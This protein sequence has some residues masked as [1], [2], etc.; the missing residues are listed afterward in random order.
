MEDRKRGVLRRL[1][2]STELERALGGAYFRNVFTEYLNTEEEEALQAAY[3]RYQAS[4]FKRVQVNDEGDMCDV[5]RECEGKSCH[6]KRG[7]L[8][9]LMMWN[10]TSVR[11]MLQEEE[12]CVQ[13]I[14][15][16]LFTG[17]LQGRVTAATEL[18]ASVASAR[19]KTT[20]GD[21]V[22]PLTIVP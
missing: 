5:A 22:P 2:S 1:M 6:S 7:W 11:R 9:Q 8:T 19:Q 14:R 3:E 4:K 13:G 10:E 12:N 21:P 18:I 16:Q 15:L 20:P 17:A